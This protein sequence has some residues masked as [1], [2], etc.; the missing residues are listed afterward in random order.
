MRGDELNL[1]LQDMDICEQALGGYLDSKRLAFP[2]FAFL[3]NA[4]LLEIVSKSNFPFAVQP[5]LCAMFGGISSLEVR[6]KMDRR[7]E[8]GSVAPSVAPSVVTAMISHD[9]ET[10]PLSEPVSLG[11]PAEVWLQDLVI[12]M[13][14]TLRQQLASILSDGA[15]PSGLEEGDAM[16]EWLAKWPGQILSLST[17]LLATSSTHQALERLERGEKVGTFTIYSPRAWRPRCKASN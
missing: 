15:M 14:T 17:Q 10:T 1:M 6:Q 3:S 9:C 4:S 13:H 8:S 5:Y 12:T 7:L 11:S 16:I 2:R